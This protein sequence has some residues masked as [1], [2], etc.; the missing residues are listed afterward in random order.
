MAKKKKKQ[1]RELPVHILTTVEKY[2]QWILLGSF[3]FFLLFYEIVLKSSTVKGN[4]FPQIG[5]ICL[6]SIFFSSILFLLSTL[7]KNSKRNRV[8]LFLILIVLFLA[9]TISYFVYVQF[10]IFYDVNTVWN[11]AWGVVHGFQQQIIRL[12][13][14]PSGITHIILYLFPC[15]LLLFIQKKHSLLQDITMYQRAQVLCVGLVCFVA[16]HSF[17]LQD[18]LY[19]LFY[20]EQYNYQTAITNFG[21]MTGLRLDITNIV[22]PHEQ[23]L[24]FQEESKEEEIEEKEKI[25]HYEAN[26]LDFDFQAL[27]ENATE[28][29]SQLDHYVASLRPSYQNEYTGLFQ[30]KNLIFLT[31]EAFSEPLI[32]E[33]LTPTLY[34]LANNGIQFTDFYQP[35]SSGTTGGEFQNLFGLLPM[36]GGSSLQRMVEHEKILTI[37]SYLNDEGYHGWAFHN[38]DY[39]FYNRHITHNKL[40]YSNGFMGYG[41]GME[42]YVEDFWPQ[43]DCEMIEGTMPLYLEKEP[44]NVY[45]MTVSGHNGYSH[46]ENY[47]V[48]KNWDRVKDLPYSD[49]IKGYLACN[50]ELED[51]LTK[52]LESLE[53]KNQLDDTVIVLAADHFPY[54]LD[55]N[56]SLGDMPNLSELYG[57]PV[58]NLLERD[59]NR[60]IIW[61]GSLE[62][63]EPI[64]VSKP[65]SS[66]DIFPTLCNLFGVEWDSRLFPGRDVFADDEAL[67]FDMNYN[68]KTEKGTYYAWTNQFVPS[69]EE[70]GEE[71]IEKMKQ[72]VRNKINYCE[73]VITIDYYKHLFGL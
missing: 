40:G 31:A 70:V 10:K 18:D 33:T 7:F 59:R 56:A 61:C 12:I 48:G 71:Y 35:A 27:Q 38:N 72:I 62:K 5:F 17:I 19:R 24:T 6:F 4:W 2:P 16:G 73:G 55:Y 64:V 20:Q 67:V 36:K 11:G 57:Y 42:E 49:L 30:G 50:L 32:S 23:I 9:F 53:E 15:I 13:R 43:S 22:S 68:W 58:T 3:S 66:L 69:G 65:T 1:T 39:T 51:G 45:Y 34:R 54:G 29:E 28:Y 21:L 26:Q 8:V 63:E 44:Y 47:L 46:S 37:A 41:N 60:L 25:V 52:L 14:N